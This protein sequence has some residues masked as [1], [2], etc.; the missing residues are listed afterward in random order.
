MA[1]H[2]I[3]LTFHHYGQ[4]ISSVCHPVRPFFTSAASTATLP[5]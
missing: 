4:V 5:V 1:S 2:T 3:G